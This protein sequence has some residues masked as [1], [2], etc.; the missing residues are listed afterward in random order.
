ML[1]GSPK[2]SASRRLSEVYLPQEEP[3]N[4]RG[5]LFMQNK[6]ETVEVLRYSGQSDPGTPPDIPEDAVVDGRVYISIDG[7]GQDWA[8]HRSQIRDW[9]HGGADYG[10]ELPGPV[11]GIHEGEGLSLIH[12]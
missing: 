3:P 2:P 5:L 8:K 10:V 11:V 1:I 9:F 12:I 7:I 4:L 6:D